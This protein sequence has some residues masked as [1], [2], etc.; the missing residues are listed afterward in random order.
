MHK[1]GNQVESIE[2]T[3]D[4]H[5]QVST[6]INKISEKQKQHKNTISEINIEHRTQN[7]EKNKG[8]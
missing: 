4:Y 5:I 3:R 2:A 6:S 1:K 8:N 7:T